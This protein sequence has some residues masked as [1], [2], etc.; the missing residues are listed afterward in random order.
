VVHGGGRLTDLLGCMRFACVTCRTVPWP[1]RPSHAWHLPALCRSSKPVDAAELDALHGSRLLPPRAEL[2][3]DFDSAA[4][5]GLVTYGRS[6]GSPSAAVR[7]EDLSGEVA[8]ALQHPPPLDT[9]TQLV[10]WSLL[11]SCCRMGGGA[12]AAALNT[13]QCERV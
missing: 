7:A 9:Q 5:L 1:W 4:V 8:A 10:M 12:G 11:V 13:R 3:A 6:N 2:L